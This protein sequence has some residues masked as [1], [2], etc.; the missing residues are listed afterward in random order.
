MQVQAAKEV[1][2]KDRT[3]T[4]RINQQDLLELKEK[5]IKAGLPY[6]TI[7]TALV[8]QYVNGQIKIKA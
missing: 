7:I 4:I 6:Q 5:A 3:I 2:R 1:R 8:K